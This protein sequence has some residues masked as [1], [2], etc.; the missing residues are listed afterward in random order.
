M[1]QDKEL[2]SASTLP[3]WLL[4]F[5]VA[6]FVSLCTGTGSIVW[7]DL[8]QP[9]S[10]AGTLFWKLRLP[11]V[12]AASAV[13]GSLALVGAVLQSSLRNPLADPFL[14][15]VSSASAMGAVGSMALGFFSLRFPVSC[16][17]ALICLVV[18]DRLS[19]RKGV[20]DQ[21]S[22]LLAGVALTYLLS[23]VTGLVVTLADPVKTRGLMFWLMGGFGSV[24]PSSALLTAAVLLT[25]SVFLTWSGVELD[26]LATGDESAHVL[27][28][29]PSV[30]RR[31]LFLLCSVLVG[32]AVATAG[33]IGFV[34]ILVPHLA[35]TVCGVSHRRLLPLCLLGG[36]TLT[37][38]SDTFCRTVIAPQEIPV[39][40]LTAL[41]GAPFFLYQLRTRR[42]W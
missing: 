16:L 2:G 34:G 25:F 8:A 10:L 29:R 9:D 31:K 39:G 11:R 33:G 5:I 41:I 15:G 38:L 6:L 28:L 42:S 17:S 22:L 21:H 14:L 30:L 13:G 4:A 32:L 26:I 23:A 40:L 3:L 37:L 12:L 35:R 1:E 20:F 7:S 18:L 27:G 36:A 24:E 19:N